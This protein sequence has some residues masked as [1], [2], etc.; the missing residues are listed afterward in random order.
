MKRIKKD[1][2]IEQYEKN[3]AIFGLFIF[4]VFGVIFLTFLLPGIYNIKNGLNKDSEDTSAIPVIN[5]KNNSD[6]YK[7]GLASVKNYQ[8]SE[9]LNYFE[10][11]VEKDP[12]NIVYLTELAVTHYK[13]KNYDKSTEIYSK[14]ISLEKDNVIAYNSIGNNY[15]IKKDYANAET[16]FRKAMEIN[17]YSIPSYNNLALM[18]DELGKK[19]DAINVINK[20]LEMNENNTELKITLRILE[21]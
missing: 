3:L 2:Y 20:G 7:S 8:Y 16:Y 19:Q 6:S 13:L 14:I 4:I 5:T 21:K 15:Y 18:L 11:A 10:K 1:A 12:N 17:P 9:A